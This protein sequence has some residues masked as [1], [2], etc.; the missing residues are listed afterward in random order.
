MSALDNADIT[1]EAYHAFF[2]GVNQKMT[3]EIKK[4]DFSLANGTATV[5]AKIK[6]IDGSDIYKET[7]TEFLKQI[8]STAFSGQELT[9]EQTQQKLAALLEEKSATVKTSL[10]KQKFPILLLK[11][12]DSGRSYL[13]IQ[14]PFA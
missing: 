6:Y 7:I 12:E 13:W 8:V 11:Q 9:E 2:Q 4:T 3:Y 14:K 10:Q 1:N 5:T